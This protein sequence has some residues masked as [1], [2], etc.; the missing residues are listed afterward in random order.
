MA[1]GTGTYTANST[2]G[3]G[4]SGNPFNP[5]GPSTQPQYGRT[6][7]VNNDPSSLPPAPN[8]SS[9]M[10]PSS[11]LQIISQLSGLTGSGG[12][13]SSSLSYYTPQ[14]IAQR[15]LALLGQQ[16]GYL[17]AQGNYIGMQ[18]GANDLAN[19]IATQSIGRD[20]AQAQLQAAQDRHTAQG[21]FAANGSISSDAARQA[22]GNVGQQQYYAQVGGDASKMV[23]P[24]QGNGLGDI[25]NNLTNSLKTLYER[26]QTQNS[27]YNLKN[28][29][30][31]NQLLALGIQRTQTANNQDLY[32]RVNNGQYYQPD[33]LTQ[34]LLSA[35]RS[36][37]AD[38]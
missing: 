17:D 23:N 36:G 8:L 2:S 27:N 15:Q 24:W 1:Y 35:I 5:F 13:G 18:R 6:P 20:A 33:S 30:L 19:Q 22:L 14:E 21:Q 37:R 31:Y 26:L 12:S 7:Y 11:I 16:Q 28:A 9:G 3:S 29:D 34:A 25:P 32:S 4:Y 10:D 38:F